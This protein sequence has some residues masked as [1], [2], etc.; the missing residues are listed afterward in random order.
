MSIRGLWRGT[1]GQISGQ[2]ACRLY[3]RACVEKKVRRQDDPLVVVDEE[4]LHDENMDTCIAVLGFRW[5]ADTVRARK[6]YR[7]LLPALHGADHRLHV[8][9]RDH[10]YRTRREQRRAGFTT[11]ATNAPHQCPLTHITSRLVNVCS[12]HT[13]DDRK[14]TKFRIDWLPNWRNVQE[15]KSTLLHGFPTWNPFLPSHCLKPSSP[16]SIWSG[17]WNNSHQQNI[18]AT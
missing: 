10:W 5:Q 6:L 11:Q 16:T 13:I 8:Q 17:F 9:G 4:A 15:R 3:F 1:R 12:I 7:V 2:E 18:A 14:I